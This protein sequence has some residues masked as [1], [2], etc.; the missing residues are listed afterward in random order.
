MVADALQAV[1]VMLYIFW[2]YQVSTAVPVVD[3]FCTSG[4]GIR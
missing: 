2:E 1:E 3:L 4:D